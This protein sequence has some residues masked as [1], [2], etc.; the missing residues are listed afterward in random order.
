M[1]TISGTRLAQLGSDAKQAGHFGAAA[2]YYRLAQRLGGLDRFYSSAIPKWLRHLERRL[3]S[4]TS[5][6]EPQVIL[7]VVEE[8]A[9]RGRN[10]SAI[11]VLSDLL[12]QLPE[13]SSLRHQANQ[14]MAELSLDASTTLS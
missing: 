14:L 3:A 5:A 9:R 4:D 2:D 12:K 10:R 1:D 6:A 11:E 7:Q 8:L 13:H